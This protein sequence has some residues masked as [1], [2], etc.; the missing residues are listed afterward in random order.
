MGSQFVWIPIGEINTTKG[1]ISISLDR[2]TFDK[3]GIETSQ[4]NKAIYD[5][6][7][8]VNFEELSSTTFDNIVSKNI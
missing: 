2:Y 8:H 6:S 1:K 5:D 3:T 7:M 4:E